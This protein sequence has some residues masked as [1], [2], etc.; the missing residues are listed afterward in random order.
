MDRQTLEKLPKV[1]LHCHLDGSVPMDVLMELAEE[2]GLPQ[3]MMK[4]AIAPEDC[5]DLK[6]YLSSFEVILSVLQTEKSLEKAAYAV[7]KEAN[8]ENVKY[9]ELRFG[10]LLHQAKGLTTTETIRA[11]RRGM[12]KA[13][14]E[15]PIVVNL[16]VCALRNHTEEEN[17]ELFREVYETS[18]NLVAGIDVAGDEAHYPNECVSTSVSEAKMNGFHITI[19]S[20]ECGCAH[21]VLTAMHM[22]ATRIGH[23]VAV[24]DDPAAIEKVK[25]NN[26]LL[27]LCPTSNIQ[28][29]AVS[30]WEDYPLRQF[31]NE[32]LQVSISTD[33]RTVSNTTLTD[34]FMHCIEHCGVT[35]QEI[36]KMSKAA[37]TH[38]FANE[39]IKTTILTEIEKQFREAETDEKSKAIG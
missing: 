11:V 6:D 8:R 17:R 4:K 25:A 37:M 10:P 38:S 30:G 36:E 7:I 9:L 14:E 35:C 2:E 16:L 5:E 13:T 18:S 1:E 28:T 24:K 15:F 20:G 39:N 29:R 12:K 3:E 31:L 19:H 21:N 34:E 22:G 23:G 32:G 33:N 26:V 27:E